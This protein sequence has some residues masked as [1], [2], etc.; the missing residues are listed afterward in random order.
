MIDYRI[1]PQSSYLGSPSA[2]QRSPAASLAT[3][4]AERGPAG[5]SL[6]PS[7]FRLSVMSTRKTRRGHTRIFSMSINSCCFSIISAQEPHPSTATPAAAL[8]IGAGYGRQHKIHGV[9]LKSA[10]NSWGFG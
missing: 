6:S 4:D 9:G 3:G 1:S 7:Y 5:S 10:R 8:Y 2:H